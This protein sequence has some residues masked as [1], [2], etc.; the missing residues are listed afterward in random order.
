[1][2]IAPTML[3][4]TLLAGCGGARATAGPNPAEAVAQ[5][6][7]GSTAV[8]VAKLVRLDLGDY[9]ESRTTGALRLGSAASDLTT[10]YKRTNVPDM[11]TRV[12]SLDDSGTYEQQND[13]T[14][15]HHGTPTCGTPGTLDARAV[16]SPEVLRRL[17]A[18]PPSP[19]GVV[20]SVDTVVHSG[21]APLT[22]FD[23][24]ATN[25]DPGVADQV[26]EHYRS[27]E[28]SW[29][30]WVGPDGLPRRVRLTTA[31]PQ[32]E[33]GIPR[34]NVTEIDFTSWGSDVSIEPPPK[35]QVR[36]TDSCLNPEP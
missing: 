3:V 22:G 27:I 24:P 4:I 16:L 7:K 18:S 8:K 23:I 34:T 5:Q 21:S 28:I 2:K 14:W 10:V 11:T 19:G 20:D 29:Q 9:E 30:L 25:N 17:A 36:E 33:E 31:N 26:R 32:A 35:D 13:S 6:A 15:L 12:I 1:M